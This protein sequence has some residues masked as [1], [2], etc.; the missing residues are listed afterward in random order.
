MRSPHS[1]KEKPHLWVSRTC[2]APAVFLIRVSGLRHP[3]EDLSAVRRRA[4]WLCGPA[5]THPPL[6]AALCR[7]LVRGWPMAAAEAADSSLA[8]EAL[9][10]LPLLGVV[11]YSTAFLHVREMWPL[12]SLTLWRSDGSQMSHGSFPESRGLLAWEDPWRGKRQNQGG[13]QMIHLI[14]SMV[15]WH[16]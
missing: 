10:L 5:G 4:L 11:R 3:G 15:F 8:E 1:L 14:T 16:E 2:G 13:D 7:M 12:F 6:R 9:L